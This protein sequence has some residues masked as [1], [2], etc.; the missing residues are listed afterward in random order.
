[1]P[2]RLRAGQTLVTADLF[3][4]D[5]SL[6]GLSWKALFLSIVDYFT[7]RAGAESAA[8]TALLALCISKISF[9]SGF[10]WGCGALIPSF[11]PVLLPWLSMRV[12]TM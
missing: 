3:A 8:F 7:G 11:A 10:G 4:H 5:F 6:F 2:F 1:M 9:L 12:D